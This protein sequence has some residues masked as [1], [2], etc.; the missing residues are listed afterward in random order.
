M[1]LEFGF[2]CSL[3]SATFCDVGEKEEMVYAP[4][5]LD[6]RGKY[7]VYA[8][9]LEQAVGHLYGLYL[10]HPLGVQAVARTKELY[11][12]LLGLAGDV[13]EVHLLG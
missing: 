7:V 9:A 4:V 11:P 6:L 10:S 2:T 8:L 1:P 12:L 3:N 13:G 5:V